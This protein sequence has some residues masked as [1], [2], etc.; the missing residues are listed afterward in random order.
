M[1]QRVKKPPTI[2]TKIK[3]C[4]GSLFVCF[5]ESIVEKAALKPGDEVEISVE[6]DMVKLLS[7]GDRIF[8]LD[9]LL[10]GVSRKN[11]H[12]WRDTGPPAGRELL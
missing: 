11:L 7:V 4:R 3:K 12:K 9:V 1:R 2:R 8:D 10:K 6:G 5:P